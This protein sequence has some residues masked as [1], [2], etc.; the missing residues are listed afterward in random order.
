MV[1]NFAVY[2][3]DMFVVL[4]DKGL[5]TGVYIYNGQSFVTKNGIV[6]IPDTRPVRATVAQ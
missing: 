4:A 2:G 5:C 3:K 6:I 1:I